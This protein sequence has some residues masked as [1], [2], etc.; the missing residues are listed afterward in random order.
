METSIEQQVLM[1]ARQLVKAFGSNDTEAYFA[2]FSEDAT[3]LFH[4]T[5]GVLESRAAYRALWDSWQQDGFRVLSCESREPRVS[6][7]GDVAIFMHQVATR[8]S[9][10]G[11]EVESL[12]RETIVF[13]QPAPEGRWL[14]CHEHLSAMPV[15]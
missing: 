5:P 7:Q 1:A 4:T 11:E 14:A 12:E 3:F 8:L 15:A 2:A 10:G 9:V 6:V 13:R